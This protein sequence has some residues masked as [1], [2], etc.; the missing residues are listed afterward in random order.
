MICF[1]IFHFKSLASRNSKLSRIPDF[2][3]PHFALKLSRALEHQTARTRPV[4]C[5]TAT[6]RVLTIMRL[7]GPSLKSSSRYVKKPVLRSFVGHT[8]ST[9]NR[10]TFRRNQ[11]ALRTYFG[12]S[13]TPQMYERGYRSL[14]KLVLDAKFSVSQKN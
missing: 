13:C 4:H 11:R 12:G 9:K 5:A 7:S 1:P 3:L 6:L 14:Q 2:K 8:S 10:H